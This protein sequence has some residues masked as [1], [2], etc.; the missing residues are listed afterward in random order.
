MSP[1]EVENC[2]TARS[3]PARVAGYEALTIGLMNFSSNSS[4]DRDLC[5]L[6]EQ[7]HALVFMILI[8]FEEEW[9]TGRDLNP[10]PFGHSRSTGSMRT[11]RS[12][13]QDLIRLGIPG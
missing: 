3:R 7:S 6:A 9:W 8:P 13:A 12:S 10:R 11:E 1:E 2:S 4:I 5:F